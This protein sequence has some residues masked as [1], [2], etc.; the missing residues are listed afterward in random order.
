MS[1]VFSATL[2]PGQKSAYLHVAFHKQDLLSWI[3]IFLHY[4]FGNYLNIHL[5]E[6]NTVA[7]I[8]LNIHPSI[9][10]NLCPHGYGR[11]GAYSSCH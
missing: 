4:D 8:I 9:I 11:A 6:Q 10:L 2:S 5:I 1:L 3:F 7:H